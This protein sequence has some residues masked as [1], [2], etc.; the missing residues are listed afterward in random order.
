MGSYF[1]KNPQYVIQY[2]E[3]IIEKYE[4]FEKNHKFTKIEDSLFVFDPI[5]TMANSSNK[6]V[7]D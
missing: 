1:S 2:D 4:E 3:D 5:L 7:N 6:E